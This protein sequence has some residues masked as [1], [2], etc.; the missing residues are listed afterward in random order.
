MKFSKGLLAFFLTM[1]IF[2]MSFSSWA[3]DF[4]MDG[5]DDLV[6]LHDTNGGVTIWLMGG[7]GGN[8][9]APSTQIGAAILQ[10]CVVGH[11]NPV[12]WKI[13]FIGDVNGDGKSDLVFNSR[14]NNSIA[15]W[16][17]DG[18]S[19]QGAHFVGSPGDM[20]WKIETG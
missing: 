7:F 13:A 3:G 1:S 16:F 20:G 2:L 19:L 9:S 11:V 14:I 6:W 17:L 8:D 15:V 10:A 4:N 18:C 12:E 5:T